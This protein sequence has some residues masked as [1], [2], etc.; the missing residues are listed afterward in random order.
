MSSVAKH[1]WN[2]H[3]KKVDNSSLPTKWLSTAH[4]LICCNGKTASLNQV[5]R[6][7]IQRFT[8]FFF[9]LEETRRGLREVEQER[10]AGGERGGGWGALSMRSGSASSFVKQHW[11]PWWHFPVHVVYTVTAITLRP[12]RATVQHSQVIDCNCDWETANNL[13][14]WWT[15]RHHG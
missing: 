9:S 6:L 14:L 2:N 1:D 10:W 8:E 5:L 3:C 4:R 11:S 12:S 7:H 15:E 13:A